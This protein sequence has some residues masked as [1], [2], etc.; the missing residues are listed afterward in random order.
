MR[1]ALLVLAVLGPT[2][3]GGCTEDEGT[4]LVLPALR[5]RVT[6]GFLNTVAFGEILGSASGSRVHPFRFDSVNATI[7]AD[8]PDGTRHLVA[9]TQSDEPPELLANVTRVSVERAG[10]DYP[11]I[12]EFKPERADFRISVVQLDQCHATVNASG[13]VQGGN[14]PFT[15]PLLRPGDTLDFTLD[16][17]A[18]ECPQARFEFQGL[19]MW[20]VEAPRR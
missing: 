17:A 5:V 19:G 18:E 13:R 1:V 8:V 20:H 9:V 2:L 12:V 10:S 3:L 6:S 4:S 15:P 14:G 11:G 7:V 16:G